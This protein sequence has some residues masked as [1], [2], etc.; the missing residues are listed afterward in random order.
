[1][2][3]MNEK[4]RNLIC[5]SIG[6]A[7]LLFS[8]HYSGPAETF[9]H[10]YGANI[11]FSFSFYFLLKRFRLRSIDNAYVNAAY[12]FLG[13]SMQEVAQGIKLYPGT[14]DPLDFAFNALGIGVAMGVY[15]FL[16]IKGKSNN[17]QQEDTEGM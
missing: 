15:L 11:T 10:S 13:V 9:F 12:A 3:E 6:I 14:Y 17:I 2:A 5:M 7:G 4:A 1:M 16:P 8:R